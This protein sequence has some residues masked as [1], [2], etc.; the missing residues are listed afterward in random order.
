MKRMEILITTMCSRVCALINE[1]IAE[2]NA[3]ITLRVLL[4]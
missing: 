4:K 1:F 3:I 2:K